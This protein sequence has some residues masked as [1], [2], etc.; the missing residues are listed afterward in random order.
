M[1]A[2]SG[3]PCRRRT[4]APPAADVAPPVEPDP[5]PAVA[6]APPSPSGGVP[7]AEGPRR[8][9]LAGGRLAG[10]QVGIRPPG[11]MKKKTA[12]PRP[13]RRRAPVQTPAAPR[14]RRPR[15]PAPPPPPAAGRPRRPR[16]APAAA[17]KVKEA[18]R[19]DADRLDR[20]VETIGEMVIAE[21]M[22]SQNPEV[23]QQTSVKL[24]KDL[25]HLDKISRELQEI[26]MSCAWCRCARCSRR[27]RAWCATWPRRPT[28]RSSSS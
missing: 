17:V 11:N 8:P 5:A 9:T 23:R 25:D 27:W 22:V 24:A 12:P 7:L 28:A 3:E 14:S 2:T 10:G 20:L 15:R 13:R 4:R 21:S 16:R 6:P 19:V 26:G 1:L 18:V